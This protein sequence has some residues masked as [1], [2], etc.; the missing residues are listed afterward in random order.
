MLI[1]TNIA[2]C[3]LQFRLMIK[4]CMK[5]TV[6]LVQIILVTV[7]CYF[8]SILGSRERLPITFIATL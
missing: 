3:A 1:F 8:D 6:S 5:I 4:L 2:M 7:V